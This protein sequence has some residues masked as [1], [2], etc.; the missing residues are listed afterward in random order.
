MNRNRIAATLVAT[1]ALGAAAPAASAQEQRA[2]SPDQQYAYTCGHLGTDC[3]GEEKATSNRK[4]TRRACG[5]KQRRAAKRAGRKAARRYTRV[6]NA[7]R[8][9]R[10]AGARR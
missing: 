3:A 2:M 4:G 7:R 5:A 6:C 1:L 8:A 10:R 9:A